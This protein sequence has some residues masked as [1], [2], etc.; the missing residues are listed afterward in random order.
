VRDGDVLI[1]Y[2]GE[3]FLV[4]LPG[5]GATDVAQVGERIR[6]AG[7]ETTVEEADQRIGI[8]V[9]LGG[10]TF[11]DLATTSPDELIARADAALY[12]T[13]DAGRDRL[14]LA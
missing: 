1:R 3:E 13:K 4:L 5:A 9:S 10:T 6:H 11:A 14:V 8:T 12:Q 7:A 2:G